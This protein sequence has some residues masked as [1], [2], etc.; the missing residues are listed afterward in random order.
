VNYCNP[1]DPDPT[2]GKKRGGC[3][4]EGG[5]GALELHGEGVPAIS[6]GD[7]VRDGVQLGQAMTMVCGAGTLVSCSDERT[8]LKFSRASASPERQ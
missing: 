2:F 6:G 4:P 8:R 7:K 1:C 5:P 3:S